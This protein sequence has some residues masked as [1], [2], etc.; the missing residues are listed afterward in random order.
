MAT[1]QNVSIIQQIID[2]CWAKGESAYAEFHSRAVNTASLSHNITEES[3]VEKTATEKTADVISYTPEFNVP[4]ISAE[5]ITE[6]NFT[7]SANMS[8]LVVDATQALDA[9]FN[10]L[11][12]R[13]QT[14]KNTYFPNDESVF[15]SAV[16]WLEAALQSNNGLPAGVANALMADEQARIYDDADRA[17]ADVMATFARLRMPLPPGAAADA[18]VQIQQKAQQGVAEASRKLT[19]ISIDQFRFLVSEVLKLREEAMA[20][21]LDYI[22]AIASGPDPTHVLNTGYDF[23]AK[24]VSANASYLQARAA[25]AEVAVRA[26]TAYASTYADLQGK[27]MS[28]DADLLGRKLA[29]DT[30]LKGR[31][32]AADADLKGRF[33]GADADLK[34]RYMAAMQ[35]IY[36]DQIRALIADAQTTGQI[37]AACFNNLHA[38]AS[39]SDSASSSRS[40]GYSYSNDTTTPAP[41]LT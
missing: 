16:S 24:M 3:A 31:F 30:D 23:E 9:V 19:M 17:T 1:E 8:A 10:N 41:T 33:I 12:A 18:A 7:G 38:G 5:Q 15:N 25:A 13:V 26:Q 32:I 37:A 2:R 6:P 35:G 4:T 29:A 39:V 34:G 27:A 11:A 14:F 40:I 22:K 28:I 20:K 21:T 36:G